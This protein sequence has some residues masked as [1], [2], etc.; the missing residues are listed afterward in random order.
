[1][2]FRKFTVKLWNVFGALRIMLLMLHYASSVTEF[3]IGVVMIY[4][5][6][7]PYDVERVGPAIEIAIDRVNKDILNSS[8]Q[9][10]KIERH[11]GSICSN[12]RASGKVH[13]MKSVIFVGVLFS[14]FFVDE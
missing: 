1:M 9:I 13:T 5:A 2:I 11:Y 4:D 3:Y 6:N 7:T 12:S 14:F 8:Y 10:T